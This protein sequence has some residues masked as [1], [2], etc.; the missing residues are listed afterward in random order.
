MADPVG[1]FEVTLPKRRARLIVR[2]W[3]SLRAMRAYLR[4]RGDAAPGVRGH[5][6][7]CHSYTELGGRKPRFVAEIDLALKYTSTI[8]VMHEITHAACYWAT[9]NGVTGADVFT[10]ELP[11]ASEAE[12]TLCWVVGEF[13]EAVAQGMH[14][15]G[16][17][18]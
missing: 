17:W 11:Q 1:Q 3:P 5:W 4:G 8:L 13:A 16:V 18:K 9:H 2:V 7:H 15:A 14:D 12:E 10:D 6:A